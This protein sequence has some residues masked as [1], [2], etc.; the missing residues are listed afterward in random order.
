MRWSPLVSIFTVLAVTS[1]FEG[2]F[3]AP[4]AV[5]LENRG[6]DRGKDTKFSSKDRAKMQNGINVLSE[7]GGELYGK[8]KNQWHSC[9]IVSVF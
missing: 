8:V 3:A 5:V 2:V 9:F 4:L 1:I 6:K 7:T